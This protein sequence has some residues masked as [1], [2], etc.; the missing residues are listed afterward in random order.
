[1]NIEHY[2]FG[3]VFD[4]FLISI[5]CKMGNIVIQ[6]NYVSFLALTLIIIVLSVA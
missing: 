2:H 1:M 5:L 6:N 3:G 4:I